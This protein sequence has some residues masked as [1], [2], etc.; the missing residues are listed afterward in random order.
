MD[1]IAELDFRDFARTAGAV[2]RYKAGAVIFEHGDEAEDMWIV[3]S[4]LVDIEA[5]DKLIE[6]VGENYALGI[7]SLIDNLPRSST[8]R[9]R[10]ASELVQINSRKFRFMV[11]QMPL[12][13]W[14]V[15]RQLA[16]R[17]RATN[18]AL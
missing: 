5:H 17:L 10:E 13:G 12:F 6:T 1:G 8:A 3:L 14:Y 11:E 4:G 15:M 9:A 7:L 16:D 2:V 18:A